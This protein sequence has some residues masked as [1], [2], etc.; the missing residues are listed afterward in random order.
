MGT[1]LEVSTRAPKK[2]KELKVSYDFG[3]SLEE[4]VAKFGAEVVYSNFK[5]SAVISLQGNVRRYLDKGELT[6]EQIVG[7]V[8]E[9]KPAVAKVSTSDAKETILKKFDKMSAADK[10][11]LIEQLMSKS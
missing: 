3:D 1:A 6:D 10:A 5:Q 7:K 8:A 11:A 2:D 9:W 4:A